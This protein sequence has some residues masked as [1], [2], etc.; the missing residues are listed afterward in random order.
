MTRENLSDNSFFARRSHVIKTTCFGKFDN[1]QFNI[2]YIISDIALHPH[3]NYIL[4][5]VIF[6][7]RTIT[8]NKFPPRKRRKR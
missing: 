2:F 3:V 8:K 1:Y 5:T 7:V 4:Q 6:V